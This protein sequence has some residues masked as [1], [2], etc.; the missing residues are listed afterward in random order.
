MVQQ[1]DPA[2]EL[3]REASSMSCQKELE[4]RSRVLS[5]FNFC[6]ASIGGALVVGSIERLK[7]DCQ[8]LPSAVHS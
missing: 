2:Q 6:L 4:G 7:T 3:A 1:L 8:I 5:K